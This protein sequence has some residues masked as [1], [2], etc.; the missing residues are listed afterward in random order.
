MLKSGNKYLTIPTI[1]CA[2]ICHLGSLFE[3]R[4]PSIAETCFR[5]TTQNRARGAVVE[6]QLFKG[7]WK[8]RENN[9]LCKD[10]VERERERERKREREREGGR[11]V[12]A[13]ETAAAGR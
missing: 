13:A 3:S 1:L 10:K 12:A 4:D 6:V 5:K 9:L 11:A 2:Q 7:Q 8:R